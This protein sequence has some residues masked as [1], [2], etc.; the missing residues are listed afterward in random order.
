MNENWQKVLTVLNSLSALGN[1]LHT[2]L[3]VREKLYERFNK[4]TCRRALY[5]L[6]IVIWI[7]IW[8]LIVTTVSQSIIAGAE[9]CPAG[10]ACTQGVWLAIKHQMLNVM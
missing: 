3:Y 8:F 2:T 1:L 10:N 6:M 7:S 9:S 5:V 4:Q